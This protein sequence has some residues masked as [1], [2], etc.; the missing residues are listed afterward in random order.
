MLIVKC[1]APDIP[2]MH[3]IDHLEGH[4]VGHERRSVLIESAR[5]ARGNIDALAGCDVNELDAGDSAGWFWGCKK[6]L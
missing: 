4:E 6:S 5:I 2:Q 3:V 1:L